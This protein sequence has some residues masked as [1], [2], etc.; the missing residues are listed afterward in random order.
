MAK[1]HEILHLLAPTGTL[2]AIQCA[3][4]KEVLKTVTRDQRNPTPFPRRH[5]RFQKGKFYHLGGIFGL[6]KEG[7]AIEEENTVENVQQ[8]LQEG[9]KAA[10][11]LMI[12]LW[13]QQ[14]K[15]G[16]RQLYN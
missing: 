16:T 14:Y 3:R 2:Y 8:S 10:K 15:Y 9:G 12:A 7:G 6:E 5:L 11:H 4:I 13:S 1:H